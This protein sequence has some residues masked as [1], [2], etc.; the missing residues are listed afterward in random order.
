MLDH[1]FIEKLKHQC[2]RDL[3]WILASEYPLNPACAQLRL[4]PEKILRDI[5]EEHMDFLLE[6]DKNPDHFI[7]FLTVKPTRRLGVYA[8]RLV[9]YFFEQSPI[10]ELITHSFQVIRDGQ[11]KGEIDFII[12]WKGELY[13]LELAVKFYLGTDDFNQQKNWIGPS[14]KDNLA[15]KLDK[16]FTRQLPLINESEIQELIKGRVVHSYLFLKGKFFCNDPLVNS[17]EWLNPK[18]IRGAYFRI[19]DAATVLTSPIHYQL[20]RPS[21]LADIALFNSAN[22]TLINQEQIKEQILEFGGIHLVQQENPVKTSF[23][24]LNN[25]PAIK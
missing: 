22:L 16:V 4:F 15:L 3:Y 2:T 13:H 19:E 7:N 21:W 6:L 17:P 12:D 9:A 18:P 1:R 20:I 10:I 8:E 24:V 5:L 11:T 14:G 23:I 25:W